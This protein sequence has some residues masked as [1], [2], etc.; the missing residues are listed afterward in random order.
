MLQMK[1][2]GL[3]KGVQKRHLN[4]F[5][6]NLFNYANYALGSDNLDTKHLGPSLLLMALDTYLVNS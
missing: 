3:E 6:G 1:T 2:K 5:C 4:L